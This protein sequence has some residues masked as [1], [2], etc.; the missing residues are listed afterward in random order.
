MIVK[1]NVE[2]VVATAQENVFIKQDDSLQ[3]EEVASITGRKMNKM[4]AKMTEKNC[5]L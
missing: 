3:A 4:I 1:V 2:G 5:N